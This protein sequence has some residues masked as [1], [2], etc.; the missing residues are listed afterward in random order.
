[1]TLLGHR[2]NCG[3]S[4]HGS[5]TPRKARPHHP[6]TQPSTMTSPHDLAHSNSNQQDHPT[7]ARRPPRPSPSAPDPP[8]AASHANARSVPTTCP[9]RVHLLFDIEGPARPRKRLEGKGGKTK[10]EPP[11]PNASCWQARAWLI[12]AD[13]AHSPLPHGAASRHGAVGAPPPAV[14]YPETSRSETR[15]AL[16]LRRI[17][18]A[19]SFFRFS[20]SRFIRS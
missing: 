1:M 20:S 18:E 8:A 14:A 7:N 10:Q 11:P 16:E 19:S 9:S 2:G 3:R 13:W 12:V 15:R 5:A 4:V 6:Q 17:S